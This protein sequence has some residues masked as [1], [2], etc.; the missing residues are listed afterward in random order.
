M[1]YV[2]TQLKWNSDEAQQGIQPKEERKMK[3][4]RYAAVVAL[5][6]GSV[7]RIRFRAGS[8]KGGTGRP[9]R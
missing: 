1:W 8:R 4:L 7:S 6:V 5:A 9:G 2:V 3:I